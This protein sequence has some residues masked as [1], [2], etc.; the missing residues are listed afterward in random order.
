MAM[1]KTEAIY[2][3]V[4][5]NWVL[6]RDGTR[7]VPDLEDARHAAKTLARAANKALSAGLTEGIVENEFDTQQ[8]RVLRTDRLA[9]EVAELLAGCW[10]L[11]DSDG[12]WPG[13][14]TVQWLC[15]WLTAACR[16]N[17]IHPAR[18]AGSELFTD[19]W[20]EVRDLR[21]FA[22]EHGTDQ[23]LPEVC[24]RCGGPIRDP[25]NAPTE[26]TICRD[27]AGS[28]VELLDRLFE[29]GDAS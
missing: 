24:N 11:E 28:E 6:N 29:E 12:G 1:T 19:E 27:C 20:D 23:Y 10:A 21:P 5:L 7:G 18:R 17:I 22:Q 3:N 25:E 13:A 2:L 26:H 4:L 16:A 15:T 9:P 8:P 14:D